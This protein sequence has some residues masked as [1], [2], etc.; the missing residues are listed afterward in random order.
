[1]YAE[2]MFKNKIMLGK[3]W[4]IFIF[5]TSCSLPET[6]SVYSPLR[7]KTYIE[8]AVYLQKSIE[9]MCIRPIYFYF[10]EESEFRSKSASHKLQNFSI[11]SA[12]LVEE[13]IARKSK[14]LKT[15][16]SKFVVHIC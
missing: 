15:F 14:Q 13:L 4:T 12:F 2:A 16:A 10:L 3:K 7:F 6:V 11:S 9:R 1:M 8:L 5:L